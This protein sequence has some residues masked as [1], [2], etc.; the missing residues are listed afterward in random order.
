MRK[1]E[2]VTNVVSQMTLEEKAKL[3]NGFNFFGSY[4]IDRLGIDRIQFLDGGTGIN[5]EQLFGDFTQM[6]DWSNLYADKKDGLVGSK[7]LRNVIENFYDRSNLNDEEIKLCNWIEEILAN[8]LKDTVVFDRE[9]KNEATLDSESSISSVDIV[10]ESSYR[11]TFYSPGCFPSGMMLGATWNEDVVYEVGKALGIEAIIF[12]IDVLLGTPNVNIHRDPLGGR[13]FEG[14]SEDPCL[15]SR[16]APKLV[17]GVQEYGV[18]ANVKH[19]AANNQE[20]NRIG[21]NEI[22]SKRALEEI[23]LPGFKACVKKGKVKT[24]MTAYNK[25]NGVPCTENEALIKGKLREEYGFDGM[26]VS[27]WNAVYNHASSIKAG[28]DLAMPGPR[29]YRDII[30][31]VENGILDVAAVDE[32]VTN[33]L[34]LINWIA[35]NRYKDKIDYSYVKT[36]TDKAA[37]DSAVEGIVLLENSLLPLSKNV[38]VNILG[39]GADK[40]IE[41]GSGSAGI[42][43]DRVGNLYKELCS[44]L[45]EVNVNINVTRSLSKNASNS[46]NVN[47]S[48]SNSVLLCGK[49]EEYTEKNYDYNI[50]VSSVGGMEGNDRKSLSLP[51][52]DIELLNKLTKPTILVVNACGP[53]NLI[54]IDREHIKAVLMIFLPGM[55]GAK[56]LA[57]ILVGDANPSGKL[58]ITFP[59]TYMDTPSALNFPGDGDTVYYGEGIYVGYRY[60]DKKCIEPLYHFGYGLSYTTFN[61]ELKSVKVVG[62]KIVAS[63]LVENTGAMDGSEVIQ[64]YVSD[65]QATLSKPIKELKGFKKVFVKA[66][67]RIEVD[68]EIDLE[69]LS[70]FDE[71][72][73]TF[74]LEEGYYDIIAGT[75]S[76]VKDEF[77]RY[78]IYIDVKSPYSYGVSSKLKALYEHSEI[79]KILFDL[80]NTYKID[81]GSLEDN[82][83]YSSS[84]SLLLIISELSVDDNIKSKLINDFEK[85]IA[86][87]KKI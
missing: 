18:A 22:I 63:V 39:S 83:Q 59:R 42:N 65:V 69:S 35:D 72:L 32:A 37:Y 71:D 73:D 33:I 16:L 82:Y 6:N 61:K 1:I 51:E 62:D 34:G 13:L 86:G 57:D 26:V 54:N 68:I 70:S 80:W 31:A 27:D 41:C 5:F 4:A 75:S 44:K 38:K 78:R 87:I 47:T 17:K 23:Y 40:L 60:Y 81:V 74:T 66:K 48:N 28:N 43:T 21:I 25:I 52:E 58:P 53:V 10:D 45:G 77:G 64:I 15:V 84:K 79:N 19:Y 3:V 50:F 49:N 29:E 56:A 9:Y 36:V 14:Y 55:G 11:E 67:D 85:A 20:T 24:V 2:D 7:L 12:G 46:A 30:D 76:D 8:R